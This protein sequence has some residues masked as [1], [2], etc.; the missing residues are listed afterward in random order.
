MTSGL[1]EDNEEQLRQARA[2]NNSI[3]FMMSVPYLILGMGG[4]LVYRG[5]TR[6]AGSAS[7]RGLES[8]GR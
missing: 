6:K 7:E 5:L 3:L 8:S 2:Y 4:L 1:G